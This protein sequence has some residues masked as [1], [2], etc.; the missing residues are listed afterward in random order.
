M[1]SDLISAEW[2]FRLSLVNPSLDTLL[3][4]YV[5]AAI[6]LGRL[7]HQLMTYVALEILRDLFVDVSR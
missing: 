1:R 2:A 3:A 5:I 7:K 4:E 6:A